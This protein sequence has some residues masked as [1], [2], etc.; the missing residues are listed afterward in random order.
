[1]MT[2]STPTRTVP[3]RLAS[4]VGSVRH[5][6]MIR[7]E[8]PDCQ[9]TIAIA[10]RGLGLDVPCPHCMNLVPVPWEMIPN[11]GDDT[12]SSVTETSPIPSDSDRPSIPVSIRVTRK[13][14]LCTQCH[15]CQ[16]PVA[17]G[18]LA[19]EIVLW[20]L[21]FLPGILYSLWR[22]S[23]VAVCHTCGGSLVGVT[24]LE[25]TRIAVESRQSF[26]LVRSGGWR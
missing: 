1:M 3:L 11:A 24:S 15:K 7:F 10:L 20:L 19:V 16:V 21:L 2:L 26:T 9:K 18:S 22:H 6:R 25:G 5:M 13:H 12:F 8:C 17:R 23:G 4:G 14:M